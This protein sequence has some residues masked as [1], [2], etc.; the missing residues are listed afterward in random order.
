[1]MSILPTAY[2][3]LKPYCVQITPLEMSSI[4]SGLQDRV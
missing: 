1:M 4:V 2:A 3:F